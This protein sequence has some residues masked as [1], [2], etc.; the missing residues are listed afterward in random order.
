MTSGAAAAG[1]GPRLRGGAGARA[2]GRML[3]SLLGLPGGEAEAAD[4]DG[5]GAPAQPQPYQRAERIRVACRVAPELRT[6]K[7]IEDVLAFVATVSFFPQ[8]PRLQQQNLC[9]CMTL[10]QVLLLQPR[11]L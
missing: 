6:D 8:L 4:G 9:Q 1:G 3:S 10:A 11:E 7:D 5:A 2:R